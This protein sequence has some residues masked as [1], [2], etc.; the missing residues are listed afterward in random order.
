MN[1]WGIIKEGG[2]HGLHANSAAQLTL[3]LAYRLCLESVGRLQ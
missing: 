2:L 1:W 3:Y